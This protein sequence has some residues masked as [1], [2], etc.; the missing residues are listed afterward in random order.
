MVDWQE[1][2]HGGTVEHNGK[3]YVKVSTSFGQ[4][5]DGTLEA[6]NRWQRVNQI[7]KQAKPVQGDLF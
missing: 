7:G 1:V 6:F 4:A 3:L 5:E 2:E